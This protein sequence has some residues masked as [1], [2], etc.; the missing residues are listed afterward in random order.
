MSFR[1]LTRQ[2]SKPIITTVISVKQSLDYCDTQELAVITN[3]KCNMKLAIHSNTDILKSRKGGHHFLSNDVKCPKNNRSIDNIAKLIKVVMFS[4]SQAELGALNC[5][6]KKD[7][8]DCHILKKMVH[9]QPPKPI[10]T[11]NLTPEGVTNSCV[12]PKSAKA[13]DMHFCWLQD[14]R[15]NEK[16]LQFFGVFDH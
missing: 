11:N 13:M 6:A 3:H 14:R 10:Q 15:I 5:N 4:V 16:Q 2:Q 7:T 8:E 12:Q 1:A 9:P